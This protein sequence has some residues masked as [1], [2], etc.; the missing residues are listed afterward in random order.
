MNYKKTAE[1]LT[2]NRFIFAP[3][4]SEIGVTQRVQGINITGKCKEL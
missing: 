1:K 3:H 4:S 2:M